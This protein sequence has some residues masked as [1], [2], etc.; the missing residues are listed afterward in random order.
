MILAQKTI[1]YDNLAA[2][3][4]GILASSVNALP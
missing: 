1:L 3:T 4:N 2:L